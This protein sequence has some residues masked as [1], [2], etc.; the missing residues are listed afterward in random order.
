MKTVDRDNVS[1]MFEAEETKPVIAK[2]RLY[3]RKRQKDRTNITYFIG[4]GMHDKF[5]GL[6]NSE[7]T[8][9]Q[10]LMNEAMDML[11]NKYGIGPYVPLPVK[12]SRGEERED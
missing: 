11:F 1:A 12:N 2:K 6:A 4:L 7:K 10:Q 3:G 9:F 8:S 5:Q